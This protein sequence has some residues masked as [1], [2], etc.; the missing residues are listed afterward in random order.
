M[1]FKGSGATSGKD[2]G[3][4]VTITRRATHRLLCSNFCH[5]PITV[6]SGSRSE[7]LLAVRYFENGPQGDMFHNHGVHQIECDGRTQEDSKT[8]LPPVLSTIAGSREQVCVRARKDLTLKVI[9][10]ALPYVLPL[11]CDTS[12]AGTLWLPI[13]EQPMLHW[14]LKARQ[15]SRTRADN[16]RILPCPVFSSLEW[17]LFF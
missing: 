12:I 2:S 6:L 8:N 14:L 10:Q 4:C 11:Q 1:H 17:S 9:R 7:W 13:V 16:F 3:V 5:H 15:H